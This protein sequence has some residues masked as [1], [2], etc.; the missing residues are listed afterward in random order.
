MRTTFTVRECPVHGVFDM[1]VRDD[2]HCPALWCRQTIGPEFVV[3]R[4][5]NKQARAS[6]P[7]TSRVAALRLEPRAGTL[8]ARVLDAVADY[9]PMSAR[10]IEFAT[11]INGAWKRI[12]ELVQGG[13]LLV[14]GEKT[15]D[16]THQVVSVYAMA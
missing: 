12:S 2:G 13:H 3:M 5:P 1:G 10:E 7:K 9:G 15:D 14:I 11:Q 16:E 8:R 6:D 4:P